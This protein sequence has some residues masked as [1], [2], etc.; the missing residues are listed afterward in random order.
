MIIMKSRN[1]KHERVEEDELDKKRTE[2]RI[3]KAKLN[4]A[5]N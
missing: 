1:K 2:R 5:D 3:L 4:D